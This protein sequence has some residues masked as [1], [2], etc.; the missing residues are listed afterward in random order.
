MPS[1]R[2]EDKPFAASSLYHLDVTTSL[3]HFFST[4]GDVAFRPDGRT[5]ATVGPDGVRIW[6]VGKGTE[7]TNFEAQKNLHS[8]AISPDGKTLATG[9][10]LPAVQLWDLAF[11]TPD[12]LGI[13]A[14]I[15][16]INISDATEKNR[17]LPGKLQR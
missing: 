17:V 3:R 9:G 6:D 15:T 8:V 11:R 7:V 14:A 2:K 5:L 1:L 10:S 16:P 13:R 4:N 12:E